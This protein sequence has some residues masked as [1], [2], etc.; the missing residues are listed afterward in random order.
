[1]TVCVALRTHYT[2]SI[3]YRPYWDLKESF[4]SCF[5]SCRER[6][7]FF[8]ISS[9]IVIFVAVLVSRLWLELAWKNC[10]AFPGQTP[11]DVRYVSDRNAQKICNRQ[12]H[13]FLVYW[14][15]ACWKGDLINTCVIQKVTYSLIEI[16]NLEMLKKKKTQFWGSYCGHVLSHCLK[17]QDPTQTPDYVSLAPLSNQ[18]LSN[19][20]GKWH[21]KIQ[22]L[23]TL[24]PMWDT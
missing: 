7:C 13:I 2:V 22:V 15:C 6:T 9:W 11:E 10:T 12:F 23:G 18:L 8:F 3:H 17:W 19:A 4:V 14:E 24:S 1:M 20:L 5:H 16:I 21:K